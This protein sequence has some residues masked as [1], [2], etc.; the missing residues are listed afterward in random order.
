MEPWAA[1]AI[2]VAVWVACAIVVIVAVVKAWPWVRKAF[3]LVDA[4]TELAEFIPETKATLAKQDKR[5]AEIHHETQANNGSSL[6]DSQR[7]TELAIERV[8][9]GVKGLYDRM[10]RAE[11]ELE[12]SRPRPKPITPRGKKENT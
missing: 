3:K 2:Q 1:S 7:R 9:L 5:I 10:D 12:Q 6:K 8:E 11:L 4:L